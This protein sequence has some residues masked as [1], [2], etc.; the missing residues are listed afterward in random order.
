MFEKQ[1]KLKPGASSPVAKQYGDR[2]M[3]RVIK[4]LC[5]RLKKKLKKDFGATW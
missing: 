2:R 5:S 4:A 3:M 1:E